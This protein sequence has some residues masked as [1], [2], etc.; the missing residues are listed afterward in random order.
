MTDQLL[1]ITVEMIVAIV[2]AAA[3]IAMVHPE[4]APDRTHRAA[5]TGSDGSADHLA[6]RS[7]DTAAFRRP[8]LRAADDALGMADMGDRQQGEGHGRSRQMEFDRQSGGQCR[9]HDPGLHLNSLAPGRNGRASVTPMRLN[10]CVYQMNQV[11]TP[12]VVIPGRIEDANRNLEIPGLVRSLSSGGA[13][14]RP[15]G[16]IPE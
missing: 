9:C 14:R 2:E 15:V 3:A 11:E 12:S 13:K 8:L 1:P 6:N 7:G 4:Y 16:T 5:D 10:G